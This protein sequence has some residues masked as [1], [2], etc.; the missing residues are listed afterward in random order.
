MSN[1][2]ID[3]PPIQSRVFGLTPKEQAKALENGNL[4]IQFLKDA[5][6]D[7]SIPNR[8]TLQACCDSLVDVHIIASESVEYLQA[9]APHAPVIEEAMARSKN[10]KE[11]RK[12]RQGGGSRR[13]GR[14]P[15][16]S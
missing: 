4:A 5:L 6:N 13:G 15:R 10:Q 16:R 11:Q 8:D 1:P 14:R 12:S 3:V 9:L 2:N 7:P